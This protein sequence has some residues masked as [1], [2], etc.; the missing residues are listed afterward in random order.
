MP[1]SFDS[2]FGG[3]DLCNFLGRAILL[4]RAEFVF[5]MV[6]RLN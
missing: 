5:A 1:I 6:L 2:G 3:F 4:I